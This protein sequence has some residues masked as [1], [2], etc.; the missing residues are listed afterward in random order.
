MRRMSIGNKDCWFIVGEWFL[1]L[2]NAQQKY[3]P[4]QAIKK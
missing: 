4:S 2:W 1:E 3:R